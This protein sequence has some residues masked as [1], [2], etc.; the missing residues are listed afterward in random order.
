MEDAENYRCPGLDSF[1]KLSCEKLADLN[2]EVAA[3]SS[4]SNEAAELRLN[5]LR[6]GPRPVLELCVY[7]L[8]DLLL[9]ARGEH[10]CE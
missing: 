7:Q 5:S 9:D 1:S 3:M 8:P 2:G 10:D 6:K 4:I